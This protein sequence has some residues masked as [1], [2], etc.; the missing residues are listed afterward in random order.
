MDSGFFWPK[1]FTQQRDPP[2]PDF[3]VALVASALLTAPP[4][5]TKQGDNFVQDSNGTPEQ[6]NSGL[7]DS[8]SSPFRLP[9]SLE[10]CRI[11][12]LPPAAY[13]IADFISQEEEEAILH[14]VARHAARPG[15]PSTY[16]TETL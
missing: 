4:S 1:C 5:S 7:M 11:N 16:L 15:D 9:A 12:A 3:H 8:A 14:K 10:A 2:R 13:Y 6:S